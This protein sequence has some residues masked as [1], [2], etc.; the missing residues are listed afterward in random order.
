MHR[1]IVDKMFVQSNSNGGPLEY[2][3]PTS[4]GGSEVSSIL[5]CIKTI[6]ISSGATVKFN[7]ELHHGPDG[8]IFEDIGTSIISSGT[9]ST[10]NDLLIGS[11]S[12]TLCEYL[13]PVLKIEDNGASGQVSAVIDIYETRHK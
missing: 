3:L 4:A 5:Y 6:C 11:T 10:A 7:L 12:T 13:R 9:S 1:K 8:E 2:P